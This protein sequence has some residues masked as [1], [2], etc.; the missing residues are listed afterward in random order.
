MREYVWT[1]D[2]VK[3]PREGVAGLDAYKIEGSFTYPNLMTGR[4]TEASAFGGG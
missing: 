1:N 4:V 2:R 3:N